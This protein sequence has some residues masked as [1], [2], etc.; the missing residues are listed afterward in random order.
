MDIRILFAE[1][2]PLNRL[3][4]N[5][6]LKNQS[7]LITWVE[8]GLQAIEV[9]KESN[10]DLVVLDIRMPGKNGYEVT[11]FIRKERHSMIPVLALTADQSVSEKRRCLEAGMNGY[12]SK[13]VS[14]EALLEEI[15][16]LTALQ[17]R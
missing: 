14:K 13:P 4:F 6:I 10:F 8:N 2:D 3:V 16:R 7:C 1:D 11:Q 12:L 5:A 17:T 9:F 15:R